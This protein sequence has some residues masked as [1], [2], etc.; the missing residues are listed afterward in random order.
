M[1][2]NKKFKVTTRKQFDK[3]V[4]LLQEN[5]NLARGYSS[6]LQKTNIKEEWNKISTKLNALG[7][8]VRTGEGWMKVWADFKFK[9]RKKLVTNKAESRATGGG[10][11]QQCTLSATEEAA[12]SLLQLDTIINASSRS[13]C[14]PQS[15]SLQQQSTEEEQMADLLVTDILDIEDSC[16]LAPSCPNSSTMNQ[17]EE[18]ISIVE[19][20]IPSA[21]TRRN[22]QVP[23]IS[24]KRAKKSD[25][26]N[27]LLEEQLKIQTALY[28]D[29]KRSLS[30]I[31]RYQRKTYKLNEEILKLKSREFKLKEEELMLLK[32]DLK[33]KEAFRKELLHRRKEEIE[34][35][36]KRLELE[37]IRNSF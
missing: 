31:E 4:E 27:E 35:E 1:D 32:E 26:K 19:Q 30:E 8:P 18:E 36:R 28:T 21:S 15:T 37:E 12:S 6:G 14:I 13:I 11:F 7:P 16:T 22:E 33:S 17:P 2:L 25:H 5:P 20:E 29:V 9:L 23:S 24:T 34:I 10:P 3:M